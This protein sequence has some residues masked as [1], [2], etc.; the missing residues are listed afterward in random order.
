MRKFSQRGFAAVET[1]LIVVI[2]A[3][4]AFVVWFVFTSKSD[5]NTTLNT[6][7]NTQVTAK[8]KAP[9]TTE[10]TP[11]TGQV[12]TTKTDAKAGQYLADAN[13]K[14]LYTY[15]ADTSGV[16]NC[17]GACL[18]DWPVYVA[19]ATSTSLPTNVTVIHRSDGGSQ[20]AY[21]GMPLYYFTGDTSAG[22]VTGDN[23]NDFHVAKP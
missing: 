7:D 19:A 23:V 17:T 12:V 4:V 21:K 8:P 10:N 3:L 11:A 22:M 14:T 18:T 13:G 1:V 9:K 6:A 20:Y 16:S 2:V 5:T 15:G